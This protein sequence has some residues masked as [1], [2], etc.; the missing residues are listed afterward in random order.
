[1]YGYNFTDFSIL[2]IGFE[3]F[4]LWQIWYEKKYASAKERIMILNLS[5]LYHF[6]QY[7][8]KF[9]LPILQNNDIY[10]N[11]GIKTFTLFFGNEI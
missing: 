8:S 1:M 4:R 11:L 9:E 5:T 7:Y 2:K 3:N 6:Q 10:V